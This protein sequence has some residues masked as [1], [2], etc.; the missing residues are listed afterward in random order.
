MDRLGWK[1]LS[2]RSKWAWFFPKVGVASKNSCTLY[3]HHYTRT[4]LLK[5]LNP[6]L[7]SPIIM[8]VV[9]IRIISKVHTGGLEAAQVLEKER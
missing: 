4:L 1:F 5:I 2:K 6:P 8:S 9:N 3:A 7:T